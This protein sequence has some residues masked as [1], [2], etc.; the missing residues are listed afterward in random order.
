MSNL[1]NGNTSYMLEIARFVDPGG[2]FTSLIFISGTFYQELKPC[3]HL[4][5][6]NILSNCYSMD[7]LKQ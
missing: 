2:R 7:I 3:L 6:L 5:V 4:G 1:I